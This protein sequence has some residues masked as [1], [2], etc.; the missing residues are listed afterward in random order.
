M[1]S[2]MQTKHF[3]PLPL[4]FESFQMRCHF[5]ISIADLLCYCIRSH[6]KHSCSPDIDIQFSFTFFSILPV[7]NNRVLIIGMVFNM[8][9]NTTLTDHLLQIQLGLL[10]LWPYAEWLS[11]TDLWTCNFLF[12]RVDF[13]QRLSPA[14]HCYIGPFP[15]LQFISRQC[16]IKAV[17]GKFFNVQLIR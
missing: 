8:V 3:L 10:R 1:F 16:S 13:S 5:A 7:L 6:P 14:S 17:T 11:V 2:L 15:P 9:Q 4:H 12:I